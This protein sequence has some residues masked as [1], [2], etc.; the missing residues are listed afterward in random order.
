MIFQLDFEQSTLVKEE[1]LK[2]GKQTTIDLKTVL[3][4]GIE[5]ILTYKTPLVKFVLFLKR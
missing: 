3:K 4:V 5:E 2:R 1:E